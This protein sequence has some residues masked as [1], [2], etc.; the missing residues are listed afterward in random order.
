MCKLRVNSYKMV[1]KYCNIPLWTR[2]CL[3]LLWKKRR[4]SRSGRFFI[5][6]QHASG[7]SLRFVLLKGTLPAENRYFKSSERQHSYP[8]FQSQRLSFTCRRS[9]WHILCLLRFFAIRLFIYGHW[10]H[11]NCENSND[12][13]LST[14]F[15]VDRLKMAAACSARRQPVMWASSTTRAWLRCTTLRWNPR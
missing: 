15:L 7:L 3:L 5:L 2:K 6:V 8:K 4:L 1:L 14:N 13:R 10:D 11:E 9:E 12:E